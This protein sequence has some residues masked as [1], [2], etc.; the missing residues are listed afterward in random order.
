[1][2][3]LGRAAAHLTVQCDSDSDSGG[4]HTSDW[5]C[6]KPHMALVAVRTAI[7]TPF[8][9]DQYESAVDVNGKQWPF[10]TPGGYPLSLSLARALSL[11][12][13]L[14]LARARFRSLGVCL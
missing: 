10:N 9:I 8:C 7:D 11:S 13:S 2:T 14:S 5:Q 1:M 3:M 4:G 12:R 6:S